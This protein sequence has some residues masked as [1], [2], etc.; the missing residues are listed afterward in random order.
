MRA[1]GKVT[2]AQRVFTLDPHISEFEE[3][4]AG[5]YRQSNFRI[6]DNSG[7]M[8]VSPFILHPQQCHPERSEGSAV[9]F[10]GQNRRYFRIGDDQGIIE[11]IDP[12][13][14]R[15]QACQLKPFTCHS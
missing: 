8:P 11:D 1:A 4:R 13:S 14:A 2:A 7:K 9:A 12:R 15:F 6:G 5:C 3:F 10:G